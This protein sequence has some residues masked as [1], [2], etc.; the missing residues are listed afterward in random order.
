MKLSIREWCEENGYDTD[1]VVFCDYDLSGR[2]GSLDEEFD[3]DW[4]DDNDG[5]INGETDKGLF[6][7]E[8]E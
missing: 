1:K 5:W 2:E 6:S 4:L 8:V 3:P 7:V